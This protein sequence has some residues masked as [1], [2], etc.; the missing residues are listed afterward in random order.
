MREADRRMEYTQNRELSWLNFNKRVLQVGEDPS[1]PLFERLKFVS[2]FQSNLS[3]FFMIRVGG[4]HDVASLKKDVVDDKSGM[5]AVEQLEAIFKECRP[6]EELRDMI[7]SDIESHLWPYGVRRYTW[8]GLDDE[9]R[10]EAEMFAEKFVL[11]VLSPQIIDPRH[12]FPHLQNG[13][14]YVIT[15]L[16]LPEDDGDALPSEADDAS[17]AH[18][19]EQDRS[20][21]ADKGDKADKAGKKKKSKPSIQKTVAAEPLVGIIP[22]PSTLSRVFRLPGDQLSYI[23]LEDI[24]SFYAPRIFDQFATSDT[25]VISVTRNAD[26]NPD[27]EVY[28]DD[29]YRQHMKKILKKRK[30]LAPVRL[31]VQG[32]LSKELHAYFRNHLDLEEQQ[33]YQIA[34]PLNLSYVFK[35]E[36]MLTPE[37]ASELLYTPF[38]PVFPAEVDRDRSMFDQI[39][40]H[41]IMLSCPFDS[42]DPFLNML[43]EAAQDPDVMSIKVTL[44][45]LASYSKIAEYLIEAAENGKDVV[46]LLELRAR[47]D[48]EANIAWAERFE[49]A[50]CKVLYGF[51]G[52]KVHSK[53]CQVTRK[54]DEGVEFFTHLSTGNY[55]EKTAAQYT[56]IA[57]ITADEA[58]GLDG[59]EFFNN[60]S[61][62]NLDGEY[63]SLLVSPTSFKSSILAEMDAEIE[64][65]KAGGEGLITIKCNSVTDMDLIEK[66]AEASQAGV[67]V[68]L[69]VRGICCIVPGVKGYT[70]NVSVTSIV[71]RLLEHSRIYCFGEGEGLRM[72]LSSADM[73]TR[74][75]ER[76]VEIGFPI[77]DPAV[78]DRISSMVAT[79]LADTDR[80]RLLLPNGSYVKK[81]TPDGCKA[82][83]SQFSFMEEALQKA[84]TR[85]E[86]L[87]ARAEEEERVRAE[88]EAA[89]EAA[90]LAEAEAKA[91]EE[92]E[93]KA[94][95]EAMER[96][97]AEAESR[98]EAAEKALAEAQA[99]AE[100]EAQARAEA[101]SRAETAEQALAEAQ[102]RVE[103]EAR[104]KA[105]A[106]AAAKPEP[107]KEIAP[108]PEPAPEPKAAPAPAPAPEPAPRPEKKGFFSRLF[109]K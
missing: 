53:I 98:A 67:R 83:N 6:L 70:D 29:D 88:A 45:R 105:E 71:G 2:I 99:R 25:A 7:F 8:E 107:I 19:A 36:G 17:E 63:S 50:G 93:A 1:T 61:I 49:E 77:K 18:R 80:G 85:E 22:I 87:Q 69:I 32:K 84:A 90:K 9:Q 13:E 62:G 86:E 52:Y 64:K 108:Q 89:A 28:D 24:I 35:L 26:I 97:L 91:R 92:A 20:D 43:R 94:A 39:R 34:S 10:A 60:M 55:N 95:A 16:T 21:K 106:E 44:Y 81:I 30:R 96:A 76:R 101:E 68:E 27:D 11:P 78:R 4:L 102:A 37:Q 103:A 48:E 57:I 42:I 47:F 74:N 14:L 46:T 104:A 72:Y 5:N 56:D 23:L 3:E 51:E 54:K 65:A 31:M 15:K 38:S 82:V 41:D 73:M 59:V 58:I 100:A 66:I 40:E 79:M 109:G 75:T 33:I 12:P